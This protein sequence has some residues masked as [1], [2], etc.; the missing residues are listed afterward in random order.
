MLPQL[1]KYPLNE[2]MP[3]MIKDAFEE[4]E[5]VGKYETI[6]RTCQHLNEIMRMAVHYRYIDSN[7]LSDV[8]KLFPAPK[9]THM[10]SI[11]PQELPELFMDFISSLLYFKLT[12]S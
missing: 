1:G 11:P 9:P 3:M 12:L 8:T 10:L 5:S 4:L 2:I 7:Q 6:K